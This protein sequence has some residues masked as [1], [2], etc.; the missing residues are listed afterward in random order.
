MAV[1]F[2]RVERPGT[3]LPMWVNAATVV[4][5]TAVAGDRTSLLFVNGAQ[6]TIM[7]AAEDFVREASR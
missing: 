1:H 5:V 3:D 2:V 6:L 7:G 4:D